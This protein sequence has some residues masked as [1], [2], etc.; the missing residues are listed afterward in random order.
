MHPR[1]SAKRAENKRL[2]RCFIDT[3]DCKQD[4][5]YRIKSLGGAPPTGVHRGARKECD[6][7]IT[8][9]LEVIEQINC[10][11]KHGF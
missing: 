10:G 9:V 1:I 11:C 3:G 5:I 6:Q 7:E 4:F 8:N 2:K